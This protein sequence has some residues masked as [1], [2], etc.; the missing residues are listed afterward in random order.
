MIGSLYQDL[1]FLERRFGGDSA[2][3][4]PKQQLEERRK[5]VRVVWKM[6]EK[7]PGLAWEGEVVRLC[8]RMLGDVLK[9]E[10][11]GSRNDGGW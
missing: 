7:H 9:G 10:F 5:R 3:R 2:V 8:E 11:F 6:V 1:R 4:A